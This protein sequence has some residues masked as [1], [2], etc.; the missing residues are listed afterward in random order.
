MNKNSWINDAVKIEFEVTPGMKNLM[1]LCEKAASDEDY[2]YFN[3]EEA[4]DLACKEMVVIG[5]MTQKQWDMIEE[6]Y[7]SY[8]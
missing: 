4:L 1:D 7:G 8:D 2:S 6:R 5:K 3:Y